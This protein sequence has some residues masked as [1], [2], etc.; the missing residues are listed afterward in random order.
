MSN[1]G[2]VPFKGSTHTDKTKTILSAKRKGSKTAQSV[3][4]QMKID[5]NT[6]TEHCLHCNGMFAKQ[7]FGRWHG[8]N[9]SSLKPKK[10]PRIVFDP[11]MLE[12]MS[13]RQ[14]EKSI[15]KCPH[16]DKEGKSPNIHRF[17]FDNCKSI[18]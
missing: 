6:K 15:I 9:C 17:H 5:R 18:I 12:L 13:K 7:T 8:P 14:K 1:L 10:K 3:K 16:C 2:Y 11:A 4:D